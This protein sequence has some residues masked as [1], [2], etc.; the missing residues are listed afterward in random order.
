LL[1]TLTSSFAL[2][3]M[4]LSAIGLY[5]ILAY[6]VT[7]RLREIGLRMA[8]GAQPGSVIWLVIQRAIPT[9]AIGVLA[10][11]GLSMLAGG[12]VRSLL[13][14]VQPFDAW[15][16]VAAAVALLIAIGIAGASVPA[17]RAIRVDPSTTLRQ[18]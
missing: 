9:L 6:F 17:V 3:A 2:F 10:G 18:D 8:L 13:Y 15:S 4:T 5:G 7:R 12:W 1:V 11:A 16:T 14:G